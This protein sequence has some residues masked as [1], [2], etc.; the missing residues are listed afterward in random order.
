MLPYIP[1]EIW[2][3]VIAETQRHPSTGVLPTK[4]P[5]RRNKARLASY[6]LVC[7]LWKPIAQALLFQEVAVTLRGRQS[8][9]EFLSF[10]QSSPHIARSVRSLVLMANCLPSWIRGEATEISHEFE[11]ELCPAVLLDILH[12]LPG[13]THVKFQGFTIL[14]W[15]QDVPLPARLLS[16][17]RLAL[18]A[19]RYKPLSEPHLLP[20]DILSFFSAEALEVHDN[21]VLQPVDRE[22]GS[23]SATR[24]LPNTEQRV[25]KTIVASG[26]DCFLTHSMQHGGVLSVEYVRSLVLS[27][28]DGPSLRFAGSLLQHY[29]A[30]AR[31]VELNISQSAWHRN[32]MPTAPGYSEEDLLARLSDVYGGVLSSTPTTLR[33]LE[34]TFW[35]GAIGPPK[36]FAKVATHVA[37]RIV[38]AADRFPDLKRVVLVI[39]EPLTVDRCTTIMNG[40]L[41]SQV[42]ERRL[43]TFETLDDW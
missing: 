40:L 31:D 19:L 26:P 42:V 34:F 4:P 38:Q 7:R 30:H 43:V 12:A 18:K 21:T 32:M 17:T 22:A 14:G 39:E 27:P 37:H 20:F 6:S 8:P 28:Y 25:V 13:I 1:P 24:A 3:I 2:E 5:F 9:G 11:L 15:P 35:E 36:D 29:G 33:E 10:V 23:L 41:P 16:L